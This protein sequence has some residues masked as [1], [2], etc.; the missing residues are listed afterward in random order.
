[1]NTF[2]F[3]RYG[4]QMLHFFVW[5]R[6][7]SIENRVQ[8]RPI[9]YSS[10]PIRLQIFFSVSEN[11]QYLVDMTKNYAQSYKYRHQ[12]WGFRDF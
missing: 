9:L 10:Q 7:T 11:K 3:F 8:I 1:M 2:L 4:I 5:S 6:S 12:I